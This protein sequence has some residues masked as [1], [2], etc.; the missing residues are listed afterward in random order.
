MG[1]LRRA[2][3]LGEVGAVVRRS[4][5]LKSQQTLV[6]Y[7]NYNQIHEGMWNRSIIFSWISLSHGG[8][9]ILCGEISISSPSYP[10]GGFLGEEEKSTD[11][12][13][14]NG[15]FS[16]DLGGNQIFYGQARGRR[17]LNLMKGK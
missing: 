14:S 4:R 9:L 15:D 6:L 16:S 5:V 8:E 3:R 12:V 7:R 11:T 13:Q 2:V 10:D 17:I 1:G